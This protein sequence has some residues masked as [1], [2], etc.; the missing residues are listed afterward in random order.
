MYLHSCLSYP[1][2]KSFLRHII[3]SSVVYLTLPYFSRL[4]HKLPHFRKNVIPH[5]IN[6]NFLYTSVWRISHSIQN[7][8]RY[9]K[10][11]LVFMYPCQILIELE[12]SR[13]IFEKSSNIQFHENPSIGS[14]ANRQTK[15]GHTTRCK[16][17]YGN[18]DGH[19]SKFCERA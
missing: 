2:C 15:D 5:E 19:F 7:S 4:S 10:C 6:F 17:R 12:H 3:L 14:R 16:D 11:T 1:A 13:Q 18:S 9:Y 8:A